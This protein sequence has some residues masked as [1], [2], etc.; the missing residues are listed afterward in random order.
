MAKPCRP[1]RPSLSVATHEWRTQASVAEIKEGTDLPHRL[2]Y[3]SPEGQED[4]WVCL[5][6]SSRTIRDDW[7]NDNTPFH[8][9]DDRFLGKCIKFQMEEQQC[10]AKAN[11]VGCRACCR[12][13]AR[14]VGA[15]GGAASWAGAGAPRVV[16]VPAG[17]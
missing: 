2:A 13:S 14:V 4:E 15:G 7:G 6:S 3:I 1:C 5:D 17:R 9:M 8:F 16:P 10:F 11:A 12:V